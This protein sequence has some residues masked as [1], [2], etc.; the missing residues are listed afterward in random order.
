MSEQLS[1]LVLGAD[2]RQLRRASSRNG[3][4]GLGLSRVVIG[5]LHVSGK[6]GQDY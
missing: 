4:A 3:I 5:V 1:R 6:V 2:W